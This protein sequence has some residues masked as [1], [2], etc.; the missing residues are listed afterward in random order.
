MPVSIS[1]AAKRGYEW[2]IILSRLLIPLTSGQLA[3]GRLSRPTLPGK[4]EYIRDAS[5]SG[6]RLESRRP[7]R[8]VGRPFSSVHGLHDL[9]SLIVST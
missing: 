2:V 3:L 7:S 6:D 5:L 1:I 8:R 4:S 9:H